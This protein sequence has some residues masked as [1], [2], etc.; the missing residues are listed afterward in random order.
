MRG[1]SRSSSPGVG[2]GV[3]AV[4]DG[5]LVA[6]LRAGEVR[7]CDEADGRDRARLYAVLLR[8]TRRPEVAEELLQETWLRLAGGAALL[9]SEDR[10][11]PWLYAVARNLAASWHRWNA[12]D[13]ARRELFGR[14][15]RPAVVASTPADDAAAAEEAA[16]LE[17][18]FGALP[19]AQREV[20]LLVAERGLEPGEV[21]RILG[22]KPEAARQR[23]SRAR[24]ALAA[25]LGGPE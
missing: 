14:R 21:A 15:S 12:L 6:R 7:A 8:L 3:D 24:A 25:R 19:F 22:I 1:A 5:A 9:R 17:A 4:D 2:E 18:A 11:G 23:L 10:L 16:R 20:L 13:R